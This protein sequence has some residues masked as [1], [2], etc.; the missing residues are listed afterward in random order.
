MAKGTE[1]AFRTDKKKVIKRTT[2]HKV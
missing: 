1:M 2:H